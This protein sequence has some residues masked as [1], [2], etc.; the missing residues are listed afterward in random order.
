MQNLQNSIAFNH[1][2]F[3]LGFSSKQVLQTHM[4][5]H[6]KA[7]SKAKAILQAIPNSHQIEKLP[8]TK[9]INTPVVTETSFNAEE[10]QL[11]GNSSGTFFILDINQLLSIADFQ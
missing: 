4:D 7:E 9:S 3:V 6:A 8:I 11:A 5:I 10:V 1:Q 2:L